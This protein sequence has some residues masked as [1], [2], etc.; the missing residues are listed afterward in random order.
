MDIIN[1][2][3]L[4]KNMQRDRY[5]ARSVGTK[6]DA[7]LQG[8]ATEIDLYD[9]IGFWG[10]TAKDFRNKLKDAA[11]D[12]VLRVNSPGGS[13]TDGIAIYNDLLAHK[14]NVRVE[15]T[16][17]AASIASII[18][19]AGNEIAIAENAFVMIH[20]AWGVTVGNKDDHKAAIDVLTK[21]DDSLARTY[22]T[23]TKA[24]IRTIK[25]MMDDETWM[26]GKEAVDHG[27][28]TEIL[29]PVEAQAKFDMSVFE[30]TPES[31]AYSDGDEERTVRDAERALRDAGWSRTEARKMVSSQ[32]EDNQRDAGDDKP[33]DLKLDALK[34]SISTLLKTFS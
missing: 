3:P 6:F 11:G 12:I 21:M 13:V 32:R 30:T 5:F 19:M 2:G 14:G 18:A 8:N 7:S 15:I 4:P 22:A 1:V 23:K 17:V 16:G 10:V 20:N 27:F 9:E 26:T 25:Q 33:Q 24:G 31:L 28:A 29:K 34:A